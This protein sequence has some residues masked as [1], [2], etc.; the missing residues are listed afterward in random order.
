MLIIFVKLINFNKILH[1]K[2]GAVP[3]SMIIVFILTGEGKGRKEGQQETVPLL[4]IFQR[5][6]RKIGQ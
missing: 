4:K 6:G 3:L 2:S 5:K 1:L